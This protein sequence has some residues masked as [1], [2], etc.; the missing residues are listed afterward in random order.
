VIPDSSVKYVPLPNQMHFG[1]SPDGNSRC[2][3]STLGAPQ[4]RRAREVL[5]L[6]SIKRPIPE[7]RCCEGSK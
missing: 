1:K 5:E 7:L 6:A 2:P 4:Y 3:A